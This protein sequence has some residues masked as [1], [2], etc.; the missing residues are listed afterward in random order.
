MLRLRNSPVDPEDMGAVAAA[1]LEGRTNTV[2]LLLEAG[3]DPRATGMDSG[4]ALHVACWFG[5][6]PVVRLL[7]E[8]VP[9]D[10]LDAHHGSPPLGWATHGATHCRNGKGDYV[11]VV[12]ALIAAGAD[13]TAPANRYGA[14]M[15]DQAG[16]RE[17]VKAVL[18]AHGAV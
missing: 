18:R 1:A 3:F 10:L 12:E 5:W 4:S 13:P 14:S 17:D 11:G 16:D 6:L 9:L 2:R 8:R 7:V 15:L